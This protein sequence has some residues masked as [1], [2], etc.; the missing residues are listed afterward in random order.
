[1]KA[2]GLALRT[3]ARTG[4]SPTTTEGNFI[5]GI[6]ME[7]AG[8]LNTIT[9]GTTTETATVIAIA[10]TIMIMTTI[11]TIITKPIDKSV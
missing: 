4:W 10:M 5:M 1:M 9:A 3:R 2:T 7:I 11:M 6:G 8:G